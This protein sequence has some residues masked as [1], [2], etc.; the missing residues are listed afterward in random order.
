[1]TTI[2]QTRQELPAGT[3][4]ADPVHSSIAFEVAYTVATFSGEVT[5]FDATLADGQLT[6]V[7]RIASIKVKDENLEAH[8]LSPEFFDAERHPE[9]RFVS[10]Q[11][12]RDGDSVSVDGELTIKGTTKPATLAGT[13]ATGQD[14][15]GNDRVGLKLSTQIDR[16]A[17]GIEWNAPLPNGQQAL[18]DEVTLKADLSL[19]AKA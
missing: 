2:E 17:F 9:V 13:I 8:L 6:G 14:A 10:S 1:M 3:W 16:T 12:T 18:A 19:V 15:Y 7:A 11:T 4:Q 5:D